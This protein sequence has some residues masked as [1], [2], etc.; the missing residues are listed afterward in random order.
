MPIPRS[1]A[2]GYGDG[3]AVCGLPLGIA[4]DLTQFYVVNIHLFAIGK[5]SGHDS[6]LNRAAGRYE[7][8][9][10]SLP[11]AVFRRRGGDDPALR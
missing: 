3:V 10:D 11:H 1:A 9:G 5:A 7:A 6:E 8:P 4:A 2:A